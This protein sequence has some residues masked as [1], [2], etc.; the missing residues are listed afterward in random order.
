MHGKACLTKTLISCRLKQELRGFRPEH[1][2]NEA[3][4]DTLQEVK[5]A[6]DTFTSNGDLHFYMCIPVKEGLC[7][8]GFPSH[9]SA[10]IELS[11][12]QLYIQCNEWGERLPMPLTCLFSS[13]WSLV[14]KLVWNELWIYSTVSCQPGRPFSTQIPPNYFRSPYYYSN[15]SALPQRKCVPASNSTKKMTQCS[16]CKSRNNPLCSEGGADSREKRRG[17]YK[18]KPV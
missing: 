4:K 18:C 1:F 12:K 5:F 13:L 7:Y 3:I 9:L 2:C 14:K 10:D 11:G 15:T 6:T 8:V 16:L 17:F